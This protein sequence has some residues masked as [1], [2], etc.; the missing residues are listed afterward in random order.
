M[1]IWCR[2]TEGVEAVPE[3]SHS[4]VQG[5][6]QQVWV[7]VSVHIHTARERVPKGSEERGHTAALD[8]L[9]QIEAQE[10]MIRD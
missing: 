2:L 7:L 6:N 4:V 5:T 3:Q 9:R 1:Q 8:H 10:D